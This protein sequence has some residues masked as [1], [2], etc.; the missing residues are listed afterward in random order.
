MTGFLCENSK[1]ASSI[2]ILHVIEN[3]ISLCDVSYATLG[4]FVVEFSELSFVIEI[5][6]CCESQ[7]NF[8]RYDIDLNKLYD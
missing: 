6:R 5:D 8:R 4:K 2:A 3:S 1:H 7:F